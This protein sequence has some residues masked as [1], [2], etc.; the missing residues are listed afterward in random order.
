MKRLFLLSCFL[1]VG[2]NLSSADTLTLSDGAVSGEVSFTHGLNVGHS[3]MAFGPNA[4]MAFAGPTSI[5]PTYDFGM[6]GI[7]SNWIDGNGL[8]G[9]VVI[10]ATQTGKS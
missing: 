9:G 4:I 8:Y 1:L 2:A 3:V 7:E 10:D 6:L 5:N